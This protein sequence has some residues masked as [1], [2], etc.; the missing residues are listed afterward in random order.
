MPDLAIPQLPLRVLDPLPQ[1]LAFFCPVL[2]SFQ[3][4]LVVLGAPGAEGST[5]PV[6][7]GVDAHPVRR[8]ACRHGPHHLAGRRR[9]HQ[10]RAI[11]EAPS[12]RPTLQAPPLAAVPDAHVWISFARQVGG[13]PR[14]GRP[15]PG[16][17]SRRLSM[18]IA[19]AGA[20]AGAVPFF[21]SASDSRVTGRCCPLRRP[22]AP[23]CAVDRTVQ[24]TAT[25]R[26]G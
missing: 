11:G 19:L 5:E 25:L 20:A 17:R 6:R 18:D 24:P 1:P 21:G 10:A 4:R 3:R 16:E 22:D 15:N 2:L 7:R 14:V 13:S 12:L 26:R 8:L 9:K 23:L